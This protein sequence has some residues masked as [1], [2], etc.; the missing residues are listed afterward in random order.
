MRLIKKKKRS[1]PDKPAGG[2]KSTGKGTPKHMMVQQ[3]A[4]GVPTSG[5][6]QPLNQA[7]RPRT[8]KDETARSGHDMMKEFHESRGSTTKPAPPKGTR[9]EQNSRTEADAAANDTGNDSEDTDDEGHRHDEQP[10]FEQFE[11]ASDLETS[12]EDITPGNDDAA[13]KAEK[14]LAL[15]KKMKKEAKRA[16]KLV[17]EAKEAA[18]L[19]T[20]RR[21]AKE[22]RDRARQDAIQAALEEDI[23]LLTSE[24]ST[25]S[26]E[27]KTA[28]KL[29]IS[30]LK[31]V[32]RVEDEYRK[33]VK[34]PIKMQLANSN[35]IIIS[36]RQEKAKGQG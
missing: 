6:K 10:G 11:D 22:K 36:S 21:E 14:A 15:K 3:G 7:K 8:E 26:G 23:V 29:K 2:S 27:E 4:H 19:R 5:L 35:S 13:V 31:M 33:Y 1:T 20:K 24:D 18:L 16:R 12:I 28:K 34:E 17:R 30:N 9:N 32:S 25:D